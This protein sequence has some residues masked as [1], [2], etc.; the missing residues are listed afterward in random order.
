MD[1][2]EAAYEPADALVRLGGWTVDVFFILLAMIPLSIMG[3]PLS[4]QFVGVPCL[5]YVYS[6]GE[7]GKTAGNSWVGTMTVDARGKRLSYPLAALR[8]ALS[9]VP[10]AFFVAFLV[11]CEKGLGGP[12]MIAAVLGGGYALLTAIDLLGP[13]RLT[14]HDRMS[15]TSV[16][17][18]DPADKPACRAKSLR[19]LLA[20]GV[21]S[22]VLLGIF[23]LLS[24]VVRGLNVC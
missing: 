13:A 12:A 4:W 19:C 18:F 3:L 9:S 10:L 21:T 2:I 22:A 1:E 7:F 16:V 15:R 5:Y 20:F 17:F 14:P 23:M 6:L 11:F 24:F 8:W